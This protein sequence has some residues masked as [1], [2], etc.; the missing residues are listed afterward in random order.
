MIYTATPGAVLRDA[1]Q[2]PGLEPQHEAFY[3]PEI[4][5]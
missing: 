5:L 1:A 2:I 3:F 4:A